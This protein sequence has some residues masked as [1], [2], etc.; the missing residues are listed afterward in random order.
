MVD[1]DISY[2]RR[3]RVKDIGGVKTTAETGFY[4]GK[5]YFLPGKMFKSQGSN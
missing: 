1:T 5:L 3:Q 2:N 4:Y